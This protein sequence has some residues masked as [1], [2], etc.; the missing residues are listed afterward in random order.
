MNEVLK[1]QAPNLPI[2]LQGQL[3]IGLFCRSDNFFLKNLEGFKLNLYEGKP[4]FFPE[5]SDF[6]CL[7][8]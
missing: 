6:D 5:N 1:Y 8:G 7:F 3:H 4:K 2:C